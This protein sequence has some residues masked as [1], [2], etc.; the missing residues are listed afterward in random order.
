MLC[1]R[2]IPD[3][4]WDCLF[5]FGMQYN[6]SGD[7]NQSTLTRGSFARGLLERKE[8]AC[9]IYVLARVEMY[10]LEF[11]ISLTVL[12]NKLLSITVCTRLNCTT[13]NSDSLLNR[14][15]CQCTY[16]DN[17]KYNTTAQDGMECSKGGL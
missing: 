7:T 9:Y 6:I 12:L 8:I 11:S 17:N 13:I 3:S 16:C 2:S 5:H 10:S 14:L 1:A 15:Y 4:D